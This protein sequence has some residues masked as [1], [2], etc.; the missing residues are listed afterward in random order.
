MAASRKKRK[1]KPKTQLGPRDYLDAEQVHFTLQILRA[2]AKD[3][4]FRTAV[5]LFIFQLLLNTG[6]RRGEAVGLEMRDLPQHHGKDLIDIRW[7][8]GKGDRART[9]I[10]S[11]K[12]KEMIRRYTDRFCQNSRPHDPLLVNEYGHRM[13][14]D[15]IGRRFQTISKLVGAGAVRPHMMRHTY[16]S[17]LYGVEKDQMFVKAQGGHAQMQ[18]TN[19]YVHIGDRER[20]KQVSRLDWMTT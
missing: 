6:L 9:I 10:I 16:L 15:N 11:D 2:D 20:K 19:I 14:G 17:F 18:T 5:R 12:C 4:Q 8:V 3:R 1:R 7:D 13:T